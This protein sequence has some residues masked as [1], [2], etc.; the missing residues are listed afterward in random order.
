MEQSTANIMYFALARRLYPASGYKSETG[1]YLANL[2]D[3][4]NIGSHSS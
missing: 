4:T 3:S 1:G 2:R